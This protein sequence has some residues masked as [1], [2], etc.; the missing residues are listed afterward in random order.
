MRRALILF[1]WLLGC[2][3]SQAQTL[4]I[5]GTITD[6][7]A[8]SW[9]NGTFSA[10][11]YSPN[12]IPSYLGTL[13]P[14]ATFNGTLSGAGALISSGQFYNTNTITPSGAMYTVTVCSNTSAPCSTFNI[15]TTSGT[16]VISSINSLIAAPRFPA[17][18]TAYGY[19]DAEV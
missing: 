3:I 14:T 4:T 9:N 2:C 19:L 8:Q 7:D 10:Y 1:A 12:G 17:S 5:S 13:V 11:L 6:S 18:P 16:Q 15:P